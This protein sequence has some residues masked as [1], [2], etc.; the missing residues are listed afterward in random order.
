MAQQKKK[1]YKKE[2]KTNG[3][4]MAPRGAATEIARITSQDMGIRIRIRNKIYTDI[5]IYIYKITVYMWK[6]L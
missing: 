3:W 2:K 1:R 6:V 5:H 4:A